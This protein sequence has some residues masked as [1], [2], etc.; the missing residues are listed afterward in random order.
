MAEK[1]KALI[2]FAGDFK[3]EHVEQ[4]RETCLKQGITPIIRNPLDIITLAVKGAETWK[5]KMAEA[6]FYLGI[7]M[8][9]INDSGLGAFLESAKEAEEEYDFAVKRG[10]PRYIL[11]EGKREKVEISS[12]RK[13][14]QALNQIGPSRYE[15]LKKRVALEGRLKVKYFQSPDELGFL[16]QATL[17]LY[18]AS[19]VKFEPKPEPDSQYSK[20]I[21]VSYARS[22]W[23]DYA[24]SVKDQLSDA[25]LNVWVDQHL[26]EGGQDWL[27][28]INAALN[29]CE[30]LA[31]CVTPE[32]LKS[33]W[34]KME[35]RYFFSKGKPI[36]PVMCREA[37]LP[38][39]LIGIQYYQYAQ[40][41]AF[42]ERL[43]RISR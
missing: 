27:D 18:R 14:E 6:D 26:I 25:G 17:F 21:F 1:I 23:D 20:S 16:A 2:S 32:A 3:P 28:E 10:I 13:I 22:D 15:R 30:T 35:Y 8:K 42:I 24:E 11:I 39:E 9:G 4:V 37:E 38:A 19:T 7:F 33:K 34:V 12:P 5:S 40:M 29:R 31:L 36:V 41:D 43:K